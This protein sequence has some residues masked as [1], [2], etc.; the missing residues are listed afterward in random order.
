MLRSLLFACSFLFPASWLQAQCCSGGS[1][2]PVAGGTSQGVLQPYQMELNYNYQH[3]STTRFL[4]GH[5]PDTRFLDL[6]R[7][8]YSYVRL[9]Y[10]LSTKLTISLEGGYF[11][12]KKQIGLDRRDTIQSKGISDLIFFPRYQLFQKNTCCNHSEVSIGIGFKMPV[13]KSNDKTRYVSSFTGEVYYITKPP[14]IQPTTGSRDLIL[15]AFALK[16]YTA[17]NLK[18]FTNALYI[19]KGFNAEGEK[20]GNFASLSLFASKSLWN[21]LGIVLQLKGEHIDR[22]KYNQWLYDHGYYNYDVLAT[23]TTRLILAPQ[24]NYSFRNHFT[25]FALNEI[26]LYQYVNKTQVASQY[27]FTTGIAYRFFTRKTES[28]HNE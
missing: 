9:A 1:G 21:H 20:F 27:N 6:Y 13:G 18:F 2:S 24:L 3:T 26:P 16:A 17:R 19:I 15:Y 25:L 8:D 23:G 14:A 10:G 7:T 11:L 12:Q 28:C 4:N 22:M 5:H